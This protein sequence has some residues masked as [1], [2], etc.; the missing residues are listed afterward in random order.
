MAGVSCVMSGHLVGLLGM[1][2]TYGTYDETRLM[3]RTGS[4]TT[5]I[6]TGSMR[7]RVRLNHLSDC[8]CGQ[9]LDMSAR[10]HCPRCG[11]SVTAS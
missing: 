4:T 9:E 3:S 7:G 6:N 10:A 5:R 11:R 2:T 1:T 8:S